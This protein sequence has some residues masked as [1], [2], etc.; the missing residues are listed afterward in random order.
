MAT[1][2]SCAG[3]AATD[4]LFALSDPLS[5]LVLVTAY[6]VVV[7]LHGSVRDAL[8]G[9]A[10]RDAEAWAPT[11]SDWP[12]SWPLR[13]VDPFG[14]IAAAVSGV[15]W[16]RP[17][18]A[19]PGR[20]RGRD[21]AALL[22]G[23]ALDVVLGCAALAYA[24]SRGASLR[25]GGSYLLQDG[26]DLPLDARCALLG[27]LVALYVGLLSLVPL[28]PLDGGRLLLGRA[29]RT[30][31]WEKA[32]Y[33][34]AEQNIGLIALLVLLVVPLGGPR[35]LGLAVLDA[36]ATPFLRAVGGG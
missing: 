1:A 14:T 17:V 4:V 20:L 21:L 31:G 36:L 12:Q 13:H 26:A 28:P 9:G 32:R 11:E 33:R 6:A 2:S 34:L 3:C 16:P 19:T 24:A 7:V 23:P 27:G 10:G 35:P 5:F 8:R 15:G 18:A 30:P 25:S 22:G 29:P